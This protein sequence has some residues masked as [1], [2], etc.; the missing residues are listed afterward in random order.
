MGKY[1]FAKAFDDTPV[2]VD[3]ENEER[4]LEISD[5]ERILDEHEEMTKRQEEC[6]HLYWH[7][8]KSIADAGGPTATA[9]FI[10]VQSHCGQCGKRM[11]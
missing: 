4:C 9:Y 7:E 1:K 10:R 5:V 8:E 3:T 6:K 11:V 2:F